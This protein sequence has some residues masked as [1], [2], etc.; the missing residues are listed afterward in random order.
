MPGCGR[1]GGDGPTYRIAA[2]RLRRPRRDAG[3]LATV[4]PIPP[5]NATRANGGPRGRRGQHLPNRGQGA[6][7]PNSRRPVPTGLIDATSARERDTGE[8]RTRA[9]GIHGSTCRIAARRPTLAHVATPRPPPRLPPVNATRANAGPRGREWRRRAVTWPIAA[10][11]LRSQPGT[12][13]AFVWPAL[14]AVRLGNRPTGHCESD[15][16]ATCLCSGLS[17]PP[18]SERACV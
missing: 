1:V 9:G 3:R 2:R 14:S 4:T 15:G 7:S 17:S 6:T 16:D 18:R 5:V 10:R 11:R 12:S 13:A 8:R